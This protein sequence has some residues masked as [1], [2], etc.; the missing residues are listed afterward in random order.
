MHNSISCCPELYLTSAD[1]VHTFPEFTE[2]ILT[3]VVLK[4]NSQDEA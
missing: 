4:L 3:S 2:K 1:L